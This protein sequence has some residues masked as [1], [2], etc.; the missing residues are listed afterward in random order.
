MSLKRIRV[1]IVD[2]SALV[3]RVVSN[4]LAPFADIEV[5]GTA[6]DPYIAR[7]RIKE[8]NP[9]V[10]TLDI[11]MPRMDGITF[12][13]LIMQHRP[14]PVIIMSSL[15]QSGSEKTLEAL[16]AGAVDVLGKP[17][18]AFSAVEDGQQLAEKIR[19]AAGARV[20]VPNQPSP[21]ATST[22][23]P[24]MRTPQAG[25]A[26]SGRNFPARS[27]ILL[28]ASTGGTEAIKT[29]LTSL[30]GDLP[31]ICI[32]QHIP[33]YFSKAFA[34]RMNQ[35]CAMEVREAKAG[36][37]VQRGVALI[38]P[39]GYHMILKWS[40][41]QYT[42]DLNQGPQIHFQRPAVDILFDSAV[43]CGA[44]PSTV[45]A[46]LTGMGADGAAGLLHLREA[47]ART[48]AQNEETCV[49]FGM[50][51]EAIRCGAAQQILPLDQVGPRLE[52]LISP[53]LVNTKCAA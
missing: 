20:R 40:G 5:V 21:N 35:I 24:A 29:V 14:M 4:S 10:L 42:V 34:D 17:Q 38:A 31:G 9:D 37:V 26:V 44:G 8:L 27:I 13:K 1:L 49:V 43:K 41:T 25:G 16:Q 3:R 48:I 6:P 50:P 51:R 15:T 7:D 22:A 45:A 30:S 36:D 39:G 12:L 11:E 33:A 32:V 23:R 2:D 52:Q 18:G 19:A 53:A 28:G 46:V 47:G